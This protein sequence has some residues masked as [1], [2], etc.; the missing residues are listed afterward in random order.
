MSH[1]MTEGM[2]Y[3]TRSSSLSYPS[4]IVTV[5]HDASQDTQ[6]GLVI[7]KIEETFASMVDTLTEGGDSLSIPYRNR[8]TPQQA[9]RL[10]RFPGSSVQEAIKFSQLAFVSLHLLTSH[11]HPLTTFP[12]Q[13]G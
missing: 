8:N 4:R 6:T 5:P 9:Q 1:F 11:R 12:L 7:S 13:P 10:L 3:S 2:D